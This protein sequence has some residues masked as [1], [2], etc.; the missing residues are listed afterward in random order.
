MDTNRP[1][2]MSVIL[3]S[4]PF[5]PLDSLLLWWASVTFAL[6]LQSLCFRDLCLHLHDQ[7]LEFL[8]ILLTG[9]GVDIAG[10]FF[11]VGPFGGIATLE[12]VVVDLGDTAG[13]GSAFAAHIGLEVGH[14]RLLHRGRGRFLPQL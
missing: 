10:V 6:V 11:T 5:S 2:L 7:R 8:L 4:S 14:F 12:K 1:A 9:V 3:F 13:A